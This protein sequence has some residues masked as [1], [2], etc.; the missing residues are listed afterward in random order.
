MPLQELL[1]ADT[2]AALDAAL[3]RLAGEEV[4]GVD[5]ERADWDRYFR[6]PALIQIGAGGTVAL[7][8]PL[9]IS[10]L[11]PLRDFLSSRTVVL[12][13]MENDIGPMAAVGVT[14]RAVEDTAIAAAMLGLPT[15]LEALLSAVLGVE[16]AGDKQAMQRAAWEARP[17]S[18]EMLAYA[19]GDVADLPELWDV[20][21]QQL[22]ETGRAAW[23]RQ[24]ME[25]MLAQ[26]PAEQRRAWTRVRGGGRLDP[27]ARARLRAL[28][29][30]RE[31]LAR[32]TD[33]APARIA[34]D[35]VLV[36]LAARPPESTSELGRRGMRR[37]AIQS[38]GQALIAAIRSA[39]APDPEAAVRSGRAPTGAD[40]DRE[41]Q[42][43]A[44]RTARAE[45]LGIDPGVLCPS[46]TL[47]S[48][49]LSDPATPEEL[50]DALGLRPW[51]WEQLSKLFSEAL[52]LGEAGNLSAEEPA[53]N[54]ERTYG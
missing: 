3:T 19:A 12:H 42:L 10:D 14:L 46:R 6:A 24:E 48:A 29:E 50:R 5:V 1:L 11:S 4:V 43:R 37:R 51:Q 26:P 35:K 23:Y 31:S 44:L 38:F 52:G 13:A 41:Q 15:G 2:P 8:D 53:N 28:W 21:A 9:A 33:S 45:A 7:A 17:L 22:D 34:G 40:R 18:Q 30:A 54:E 16:L 27:L 25:A 36:D 39:E 49:L 20:L 47:M 32:S